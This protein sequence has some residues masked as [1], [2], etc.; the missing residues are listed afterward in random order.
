MSDAASARY[1]D[2]PAQMIDTGTARIACRR[3]GSG[4]P[5]LL[6]HG[7]PLSGFTWRKIL[8]ELAERHTC[9]V[10]DLP[11]MG[12][13]TWTDDTE[14]SFPGQAR[15]LKRLADRLGLERY[16]V[17][18]QD[19]GGTFARLL[20]LDDAARVERLVLI[21]TEIPGHRPPWIPLY[22]FLMTLPGAQ[23]SFGLLLRS[24]WFLRSGMGFG[25]CFSDLS[26]LDGAFH[27][28]VVEPLLRSPER[29][30][31]MARYL[32]GLTWEPV[33]ALATDHGRLTMPVLL[34]WGADDPTFPLAQARTMLRQIGHARLVEIPGAKLLV[35]EEKPADVAR[36]TLE[37]LAG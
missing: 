13:S 16:S 28:H 5:L 37:F 27:E 29:M 17:L 33:D 35:H 9:W 2:V 11:G 36:A 30:E 21:N 20:A 22:Q 34:L 24:R 31:G 12:E 7:F 23:A 1:W 19:T 15:T 25:G 3:F 14:W 18:A 26:L 6:V 10:P 32:T 4:S 8:P